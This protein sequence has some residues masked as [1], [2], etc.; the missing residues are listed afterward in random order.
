MIEEWLAKFYPDQLMLVFSGA[1][2]TLSVFCTILLFWLGFTLVLTAARRNPGIVMAAAGLFAGGVFFLV[3][4]A[5]VILDRNG[6]PA[7]VGNWWHVGWVA[8]VIAPFAWYGAVLWHAG[9]WEKADSQLRREHRP[10]F[11]LTGVMTLAL[12]VVTLVARPVPS[13]LELVSLYF[14]SLPTLLGVPAVAFLYPLFILTCTG[15]SVL[16]LLRPQP[17]GEATRSTAR[18]RARPWLMRAALAL[19]S[20]AVFMCI[21]LMWMVSSAG[22]YS[23]EEIL[24]QPRLEAFGLDFGLSLLIALHDRADRG[25]RGRL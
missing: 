11:A 8:L 3:H 12:L 24:R 6:G 13:G 25:I 22:R 16:A 5:L 21:V 15:A 1:I 20:V 2:L 4:T 7:G 9:Y 19:V 23:L 10:L 14:A 18:E 17:V